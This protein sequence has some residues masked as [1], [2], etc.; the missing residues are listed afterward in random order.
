VRRI[1]LGVPVNSQ[2]ES[3][4]ATLLKESFPEGIPG[5]P[6]LPEKWHI[7]LV[8]LGDVAPEQVEVLMASL[9]ER[10]SLGAFE[11]GLGGFG[12]F[13]KASHARVFW[14]GVKSNSGKL[15]DLARSVGSAVKSTGLGFDGSVY[16]PHLTLSRLRQTLNLERECA[17]S[18]GFEITL[19][20]K[21][22][23]LYESLRSG[24]ATPYKILE[25]FEA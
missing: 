24:T 13:P 10:A 19:P 14:L 3:E 20:V 5:K 22:F 16:H 18:P 11:L 9:R 15:H 1:F 21:K 25:S 8:F 7:T 23:H 6:V 4:I 12:C 17:Q 2:V